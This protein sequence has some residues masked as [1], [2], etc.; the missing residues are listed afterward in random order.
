MRSIIF[1]LSV[2][3]I[4][5]SANA[6]GTTST[7]DEIRSAATRFLD[8]FAEA[9]S[10][11]GQSVDYQIGHLDPRLNLAP[12]PNAVSADF[13]GDPWTTSQPTLLISC[14]GNRPWRMYLPVSLTITGDVF[15]AAQ[16]IGR[17]ER[18]TAAMLTPQPGELN[19]SR[20]PPITRIEDLLGKEMTRSINRGTVLTSDLIVEPDTVQRG[21]HVIIVARSGNYTVRT[22]GQALANGQHGEQ[23]LVENLSSQRRIRARVIAPGMVEIPM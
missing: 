15:S 21:D 9:R 2:L 17:G 19:N 5:T 8:Q 22:R 4:A 20:R 10:D 11:E 14:D 23:I 13:N 12:C 6:T 1:L 16:P 7:A 18:I 3:A